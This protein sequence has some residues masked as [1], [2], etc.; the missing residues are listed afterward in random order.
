M[1]RRAAKHVS[2]LMRRTSAAVHA[3]LHALALALARCGELSAKR[4]STVKVVPDPGP[5]KC[6]LPLFMVDS[7]AARGSSPVSAAGVCCSRDE[8]QFCA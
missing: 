6:F 3:A 2:D 1:V 8:V 5:Q 7:V 4:I